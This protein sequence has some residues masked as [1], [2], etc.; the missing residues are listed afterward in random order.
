LAKQEIKHKDGAVRWQSPSNI[1]LI[2]Y[3]GKKENQIP[4]NPSL[5]LTLKTSLSD[6]HLIYTLG[7]KSNHPVSFDFSFSGNEKKDFEE[8]IGKFLTSLLSEMPFLDEYHL[9]IFS[10]N[11]S[12]HSAGIASSASA[13]SALALCLVSME[14]DLGI[15][16][17]DFLSRASHIARLGSGS[18]SRS[19]YGCFCAWG[20]T[21]EIPE[22]SD[23]F[24][25]ELNFPYH[26]HFD[27]L[28][29]AILIIHS[30][31]KK[32]SSR[33]GHALMFQNPFANARFEQAK[34]HFSLLLEILKTGN[35][36]SF[37]NLIES[38]ALSLHAM[39]MT[40]NPAYFL[41]HPETMKV[42]EIIQYFREQSGAGLGF[43]LDAGPNVH[44]LYLKK[45]ESMVK[46]F[47]RDELLSH[48]ENGAGLDDGMGH[49]PKK[50]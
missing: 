5:S 30:G 18:A 19:L 23:L 35:T 3:W 45:D 8:K 27:N 4:M 15:L 22:S 16:S 36:R 34:R 39:M 37:F 41:L 11:T 48:C 10:S 32:V 40:S 44:L 14:R 26:P 13:M 50:L 25:Y 7:K 1:A 47:I 43:T 49:G 9:R 21:P 24:A 38:E 46:E 2:K 31:K 29:D 20:K 17:E 33:A 28:G 42:I 6:T 12:P